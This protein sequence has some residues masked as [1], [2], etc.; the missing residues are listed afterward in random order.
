VG[1]PIVSRSFNCGKRF[2]ATGYINFFDPIRE[3]PFI[4]RK[5]GFV[6]QVFHDGRS[7]VLV[8]TLCQKRLYCIKA[9]DVSSFVPNTAQCDYHDVVQAC[10]YYIKS[11][12]TFFSH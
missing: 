3:A 5:S 2:V 8:L 4:E 9:S 6:P 10:R 7:F 12:V 11:A 1:K